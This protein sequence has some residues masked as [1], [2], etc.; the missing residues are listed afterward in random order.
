M[1]ILVVGDDDLNGATHIKSML[2]LLLLEDSFLPLVMNWAAEEDWSDLLLFLLETDSLRFPSILAEK[3]TTNVSTNVSRFIQDPCAILRIVNS[4]IT[5][6]ETEKKNRKVGDLLSVEKMNSI[7]KLTTY[8]IPL[9]AVFSVICDRTWQKIMKLGE[10]LPTKKCIWSALRKS[11]V[12]DIKLEL[13]TVLKKENYR[14]F[15]IRFLQPSPAES[16]CLH[17]C[18]QVR[19]ILDELEKFKYPSLVEQVRNSVIEVKDTGNSVI[20]SIGHHPDSGS[21]F[22]QNKATSEFSNGPT[23]IVIKRKGSFFATRKPI[24]AAPKSASQGSSSIAVRGGG[25][26]LVSFANPGA[27]IAAAAL[28]ASQTERGA[29]YS[30]P[31][32]AFALLLQETRKLHRKFFNSAISGNQS[33]PMSNTMTNSRGFDFN[34]TS[35]GSINSGS[36]TVSHKGSMESPSAHPYNVPCAG[37]SETLRLELT[38][39][40]AQ[41]SSVH[42]AD[43]DTL[44]R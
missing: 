33:L 5:P 10:N 13:V 30:D 23:V 16:A 11:V 14:S 21:Y 35:H 9:A 34:N 44:E 19:Y 39:T 12:E 22:G 7:K 18:L 2:E 29:D 25:D 32:G 4:Y 36:S 28:A 15:L 8:G 20:E 40:L 1:R 42:L 6:H 31:S 24:V 17:C 43:V 41:T 37:P 3:G 26:N 38:A 27:P